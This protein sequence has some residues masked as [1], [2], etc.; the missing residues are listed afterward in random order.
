MAGLQPRPLLFRSYEVSRNRIDAFEEVR[1]GVDVVRDASRQPCPNGCSSVYFLNASKY[2]L[3]DSNFSGVAIS[4]SLKL[5]VPDR[6]LA[7]KAKRESSLDELGCSFER[8]IRCGCEKDVPVIRHHDE[9]VQGKST[10]FAILSKDIKKKR[11][12]GIDLEETAAIGG[13][14]GDEKC[15]SLLRTQDSS[16]D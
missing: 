4:T 7:F 16:A 6:R 12:V 5:S 11:S 1:R 9:C 8:D 3:N 15:T 13:Y 2:F 14:G 10:L